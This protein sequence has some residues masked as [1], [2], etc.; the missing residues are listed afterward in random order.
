MR[1]VTFDICSVVTLSVLLIS[2][3]YRKMTK[4]IANI[5]FLILV[6]VVLASGIF[7]IARI[8]FPLFANPS[9]SNVVWLYIL[10]FIYFLTRNLTTPIFVLFVYAICGMWHEFETEVMLHITWAIPTL[11]II[12]MLLADTFLHKIFY[13]TPDLVYNRGPWLIYLC[14]CA[15]WLILY[16]AVCIFYNK[17]M[18]SKTKFSLLLLICVLNILGVVFQNLFPKYLLEVFATTYPLLLISM[19]VQRP[20]EIIDLNSGSLNYQAFIEE[21]KRNFLAKRKFRMVITKIDNYS[22][23]TKQLG[24][25]NLKLFL[26]QIIKN[27]YSICNSDELDI[28]YIEDGTFIIISHKEKDMRFEEIARKICKFF[29]S[30]HSI[31]KIDLMFDFKCCF[32]KCPEDIKDYDSAI[33]FE[34][35]MSDIIRESNILIYLDEIS[36]SRDFQIHYRID[37]IISK[38]I[39]HQKFEMFYQPIYDIK[40]RK[41]I[42]AEALIRLKDDEMGSIPPGIFIP[43]AEKS[44][45]IHQIGEFVLEDVIRFI[46]SQDFIQSGLEY[47]EMNLSIAQCLESNLTDKVMKFLDTYKVDPSNINLE[48]TETAQ[49]VDHELIEKNINALVQNGVSFSLDDYGTGYSNIWRIAKLPLEIIKMDKSFV[50]DLEKPGMKTVITE[51]VSMLKKMNKK[52]LIEGVETYEEYDYFR[53]IGCDYVQGYYFSKPLAKKDFLNLVQEYNSDTEGANLL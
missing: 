14:A 21:L 51:T 27:L 6:S 44:G 2:L 23:I 37:Q 33:S 24:K 18:L 13:I 49:L 9:A 7:D 42:S 34:K 1:I 53:N 12:V 48:I 16:A 50:D 45:A 40:T 31:N 26:N 11:F 8:Y 38:A 36:A 35:N 5:V 39:I 43:A 15:I 10:N 47:I 46:S 30:K 28:Y 19:V 20:E 22:K 25:K 3:F 17:T 52:I 41:F 4:G 32:V 29:S